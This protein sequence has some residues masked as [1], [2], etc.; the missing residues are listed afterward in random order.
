MVK[1]VT[2]SELNAA[3]SDRKKDMAILEGKLSM[4]I[5]VMKHDIKEIK[6]EV[7]SVKAGMTSIENKLDAALEKKADQSEVDEI[8]KG[9]FWAVTAALGLLLTILG[10]LIT[11]HIGG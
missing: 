9:L 1:N 11:S 2:K 3:V 6:S 4:E 5:E 8:K 10:Y 7:C